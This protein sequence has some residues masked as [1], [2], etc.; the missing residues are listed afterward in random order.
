MRVLFLQGCMGFKLST[1]ERQC[2]AQSF[3]WVGE[4]WEPAFV[5]AGLPASCRNIH[6]E[7]GSPAD[8]AQCY[9]C[10]AL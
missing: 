2:W 8:P 5:L 6:A 7:P 3:L 10:D 1:A 4:P 9:S